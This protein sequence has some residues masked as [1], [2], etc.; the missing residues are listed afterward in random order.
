M[1]EV[2]QARPESPVRQR[3]LEAAT[4]M[5]REQGI[6]AVSAD[7]ILAEA[8][9]AKVTFYRHFPTKDDLVVAYLEAE[10]EGARRIVQAAGS[11]PEG[12]RMGALARAIGDEMCAPGFRGCP[13]I[14]A[15]AEYADPDHPVREVVSRF[16]GWLAE[17]IADRLEAVGVAQARDRADEIMMLRDGAMVAGY[18]SG[19]P[20]SVTAALRRAVGA[21]VDSSD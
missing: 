3:I 11:L 20:E 6:R 1:T 17:E 18:L 5:F 16:R 8:G 10:L 9:C 13:F 2:L 19:D 15:A 21:I 14:N 12:E 4:R 7:R